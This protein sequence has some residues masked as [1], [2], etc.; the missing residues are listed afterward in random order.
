MTA[1]DAARTAFESGATDSLAGDRLSGIRA[2]AV[3]IGETERRTFYLAERGLIPV[4]KLGATWI[5]SRK[6]L[7]EHFARLTS[8]AP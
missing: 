4:G 5:A 3:F 7:R 6:A 1:K 2:I 8:G